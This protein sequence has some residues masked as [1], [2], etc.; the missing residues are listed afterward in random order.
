MGAETRWVPARWPSLA[1]RNAGLL[2][3]MTDHQRYPVGHLAIAAGL[4]TGLSP[5]LSPV[6][7]TVFPAGWS[8]P[9]STGPDSTSQ[10]SMSEFPPSLRRSPAGTVRMQAEEVPLFVPMRIQSVTS[11]LWLV[12]ANSVSRI[13]P[14]PAAWMQTVASLVEQPRHY[15]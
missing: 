2:A 1:Y 5:G 3:Q 7:S 4:S 8:G 15:L 11:S 13:S 14:V 9:S 12:L 6:L 10:G